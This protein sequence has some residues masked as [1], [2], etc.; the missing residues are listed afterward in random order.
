MGKENELENDGRYSNCST[1]VRNSCGLR[2]K[3]KGLKDR[4]RCQEQNGWDELE[5]GQNLEGWDELEDSQDLEGWDGTGE[6]H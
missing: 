5:D 6:G 4:S 2:E 1:G 3:A